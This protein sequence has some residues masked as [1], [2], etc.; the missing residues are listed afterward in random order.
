VDAP[1]TENSERSC[2][3]RFSW[4]LAG[5]LAAAVSF[6]L[7]PAAT[8]SD[9][10]L[11]SGA[12]TF[13]DSI[14]VN[15]HTFYSDTAYGDFEAIKAKLGELG[16]RHIRENLALDRPDQYEG[17]NELAAMGVKS[18]LILGEPSEE[19]SNLGEMIS[20]VDTDLGGAVDAVEGPNEFDMKGGPNWATLLREYQQRLYG[21]IKA[22]PSLAALPVIGPSIVQRTHQEE[23][24]DISGMLDYGNIH[25]YPYG[26]RP[27]SDLSSQLGRAAANSGAKP[28]IATE[29]GYHTALNWGG[30]H[31]AVS[32]D[33]MATYVPRFFLDYFSRGIPRT[34][35]YELVDEKPDPANAD[36]ESNFG[37]L[38]NDFSPKPAFVA[39]HNTIA[40]LADPGPAFTPESL[41]YSVGG[42]RAELRQVLLQKRDGSFYLALWRATSVWDPSAKAAL[43]PPSEAVTLSF[44]RQVKSAERYLPNVSAAGSPLSL[45]GGGPLT[46]DVGPQ[47]VILRLALGARTQGRIRVWVAKQ[48]VPAGGRVAVRGRLPSQAAGR[49]LAVRIQRW[50]KRGWQTVGRSRTSKSGVFRKKIR[51]PAHTHSRA[52]RLRVVAARAKP[53]KAV[54]LRIRH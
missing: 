30:E 23:L 32:E 52:S 8:A 44:D 49:S 48:S 45:H 18:T 25:P 46:V 15:T 39:L 7:A 19:A 47:V 34:F 50:H 11:A 36:R 9:A 51:V 1:V 12:D 26:E 28:V 6:V 43:D 21:A 3:H 54:R 14:G 53:S 41:D 17:L 40:I 13:V 33:A 42:S 37:L 20:I 24:G 27:E 35:S 31:P 38:R 4:W 10:H 16:V 22:D 29:T 5:A 2:T